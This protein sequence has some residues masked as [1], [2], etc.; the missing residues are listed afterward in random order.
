MD[1]LIILFKDSSD[2]FLAEL[3]EHSIAYNHTA[4][5]SGQVMASGTLVAIAQAVASSTAFAAIVVAWLKARS[6]RKIIVTTEDNRV[7]HLEG[8]SLA[9]AEKVLAMAIRI[10]AIDTK[11]PDPPSGADGA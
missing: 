2:S 1:T 8:Y 5:L 10:A 9:E 7:F 11:K 4:A 3:D 6:S